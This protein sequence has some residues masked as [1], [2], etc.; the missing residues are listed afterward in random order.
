MALAE[1][2]L[3]NR[4]HIGVS[5]LIFWWN[6]ALNT[7]KKSTSFTT[8]FIKITVIFNS[9]VV[10]INNNFT[11]EYMKCLSSLLF[12]TSK[13]VVEPIFTSFR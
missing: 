7:S 6:L 12:T 1:S 9:P 10:N 4:R 11:F 8:A 2:I 3:K 13:S 5:F